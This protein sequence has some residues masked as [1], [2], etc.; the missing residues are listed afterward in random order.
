L[1]SKSKYAILLISSVLVIY[2]I[3]GGVLG[4]VSAQNG[5]Y[6]QL[7]IFTEV[8]SRIQNDYVDEPNVKNAVDGAIRGLVESID[9]YGGYLTPK[10]VAFYKD[11]APNPFKVAGIGAILAKPARLGYPVIISTISGGPAAKAGLNSGDILESIDGMTTRELN[12]IQIE[13]LLS[14]PIG[15]TAAISVI[16]ARRNDPEV[17]N[18]NRE[19]VPAP[20]VEA[21]MLESNIA[22]VK[23]PLLAPGKAQEARRQLD[24]LLKKGANNIILDLRYTAGG[25]D[26]E[27]LQVANL[28][29]ESGTLAYVGSSNSSPSQRKPKEALSADPKQVLTKVPVAVLINQGTAGAAELI[30]GAIEDNHRGQVVGVK[31]FGMGAVQKLIPLDGGYGLLIS[32]AKYFTPGGKE[33]QDAEPQ[34]SGIKPTLEIRQT[35]EENVDLNDDAVEVPPPPKEPVKEEDRQLNKAIEILKDPSKISATNKAA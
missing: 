20:A 34:D 19:V 13:S 32:T 1:N 24:A 16:R 2:A 5:S 8:L 21:K 23:I 10:D 28:F 29:V 18:V 22:Y 6:Q 30:A 3:I 31:S 15:K 9:P 11:Y 17:V 12:L 14:A 4:R 35:V 27:A 26:K 33:I 25:D 7:A